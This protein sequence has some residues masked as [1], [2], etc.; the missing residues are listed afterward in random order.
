MRERPIR[1]DALKRLRIKPRTPG[2]ETRSPVA[3][4]LESDQ[5]RD[6]RFFKE[7]RLTT[8]HVTKLRVKLK[9]CLEPRKVL[10]I[11]KP[12]DEDTKKLLLSLTKI[13]KEHNVKVLVEQKTL[14]NELGGQTLENMEGCDSMEFHR[15]EIDFV[16]CLGGDGTMIWTA[17]KF[18]RKVPPILAF[19][20]GSLGFMAPFTHDL[21]PE[22]VRKVL[23][24]E[25]EA[26]VRTRIEVTV[27]KK[28][29]FSEEK[30]RKY[31]VLNELVVDRGPNGALVNLEMFIGD[32]EKPLTSV[33]ADGIIV[34]TPTGSTAYS[35]ASGGS[36]VHPAI[37]A[38]VVTPICPH[39]LSFR[40]VVVADST[41]VRLR[42]PVHA[43]FTAYA[44]FDGKRRVELKHGEYIECRVSTF[45]VTAYC[46]ENENADWFNAI[47]KSFHWNERLLQKKQ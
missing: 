17:K 6:M 31:Q 36:M 47:K 34:A 32:Q 19:S 13:L 3:V 16:V 46:H 2:D 45:P 4:L 27:H 9:F 10:I 11:K 43:R 5:S 29:K 30:V 7:G 35:L 22:M 38:M 33:Q 40:P 37:P 23:T 18:P 24:E 25:L 20:M 41:Y 12:K 15:Q 39:T 14:S 42:V 28:N 26:T 21:A 1:P 8:Q 44:S